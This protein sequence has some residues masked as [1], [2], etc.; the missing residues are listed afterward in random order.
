[1]LHNYKKAKQTPWLWTDG[2]KVV[3]TSGDEGESVGNS[4][5]SA[6][7][8]RACTNTIQGENDDVLFSPPENRYFST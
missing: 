7:E 1:M 4:R 6:V 3:E 5:F 2:T 8:G